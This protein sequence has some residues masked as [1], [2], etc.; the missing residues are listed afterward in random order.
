MRRYSFLFGITSRAFCAALI[1]VSLAGCGQTGSL[2]LRD[3]PPIGY[4][5][6]KPKPPKP[7][8]YPA[9]AAPAAD[10]AQQK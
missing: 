7:V 6:P 10:D 9:E 2:Y 5:P 4:K 3:N 1:A 8:P